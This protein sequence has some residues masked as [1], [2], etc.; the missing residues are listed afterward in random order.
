MYLEGLPIIIA[1][2]GAY[3]STKSDIDFNILQV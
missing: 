1:Y 2:W 3:H